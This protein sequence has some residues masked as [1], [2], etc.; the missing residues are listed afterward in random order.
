MRILPINQIKLGMKLA[1]NIYRYDSL[2]AFPKGITIRPFELQALK[3]YN[4]EYVLVL[5]SHQTIGKKDDINFTLDIIEAVYKQNTLWNGEFGKELYDKLESRIIKNK[6]IINYLNEL[7]YLDS[8]SFA[9]C[10]NI[11][12]VIGLL[13]SVEEKVDNEL[14]HLVLLTLLHDIGRIKLNNVFNKEG[15]LNDEEFKMLQK[16]PEYSFDLLK[17]AGFTEYELKFVQETH[18][19]YDGSGY[20]MKL[21]GKEI[22]NLAQLILI[23]DVYNALSSF[24]PY[25]R[26]YLPYEVVQMINEERNKGFGPDYVDF[27]LENFIPYRIGCLVEL[28]NGQTAVVKRLHKQAKTLPVVDIVNEET[29]KQIMTIDLALRKDLRIKKIIQTY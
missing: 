18:E 3:Q 16:H 11:S 23:A 4:I 9:H 28:N 13:L 12:I 8:Y 5:D 10:I 26:A 14:V 24:R 2:L 17:K 7:R 1:Q 22:S 6:K 19:K 21:K 15:K 29:G 25:R 20:P 27:F